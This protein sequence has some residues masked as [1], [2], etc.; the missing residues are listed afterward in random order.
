MGSTKTADVN[1]GI[2]L[3]AASLVAMVVAI[4]LLN[5]RDSKIRIIGFI[6]G[7]A[8]ILFTF[9][10]GNDSFTS[11]SIGDGYIFLCMVAQA[12]SFILI[13]RLNPTFDPRL[14]TGYMLVSG[15]V[16]IFM[17]GLWL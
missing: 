17:L 3:G 12:I 13:G 14:L 15:S 6:A 2:I 11:I 9:L 8:G 7:F 10:A 1:E 16:V 5:T 4:I